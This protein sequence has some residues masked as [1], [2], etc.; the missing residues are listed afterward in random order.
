[1]ATKDSGIVNIHGKEYQTVAL[2]VQKFREA[3][4]LYALTT[5]IIYRD[6]I[7]VVMKAIIANEEGRILATG[8]S[9]E[10]RV[11]QINKTSALENGETSAIGRALAALGLGGTEFA[12]ANEVQTAIHQQNTPVPTITKAQALSSVDRATNGA[13]LKYLAEKMK[14][15]CERDLSLEEYS[16]VSLAVEAKFAEFRMAAGHE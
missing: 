8:H 16:E 12:S 14:A 6:E 1:M 3:Y 7:E 2:R 4:P 11:G 13:N 10:K 9:E 5:E 15:D